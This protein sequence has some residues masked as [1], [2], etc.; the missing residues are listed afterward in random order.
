MDSYTG[1]N[2]IEF[3]VRRRLG[4]KLEQPWK[5]AVQKVAAA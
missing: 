3:H 2:V 5:F 4:G 1:S